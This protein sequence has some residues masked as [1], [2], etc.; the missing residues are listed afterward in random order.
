MSYIDVLQKKT[1]VGKR[2]AIIGAG[3]IG[4]DVAE[5]LSHNP[6]EV[7]P[8]LDVSAYMRDWGVDMSQSKPGGLSED[9]HKVCAA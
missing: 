3:G 1:N 9:P 4:F 2:V 7:S 8:S 6:E 5:F